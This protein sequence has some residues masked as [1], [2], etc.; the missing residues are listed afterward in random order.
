MRYYNKMKKF[1][2]IYSG[3][4]VIFNKI[5]KKKDIINNNTKIL[6]NLKDYKEI[7]RY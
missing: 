7:K 3:Y 1:K 6:F 4:G 5:D 2:Y